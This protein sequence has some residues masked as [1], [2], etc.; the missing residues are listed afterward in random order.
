MVISGVISPLTWVRSIVTLLR[1][2]L[3]TTTHEHPSS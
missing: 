3:L 1:E 2:T